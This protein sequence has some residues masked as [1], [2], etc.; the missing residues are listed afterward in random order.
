MLVVYCLACKARDRD[1]RET[2][3]TTRRTNYYKKKGGA[4]DTGKE[5]FA[6]SLYASNFDEMDAESAIANAR[7]LRH[8]EMLGAKRKKRK[9]N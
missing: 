6:S 1:G 7:T 2:R 4:M 3:V 5:V 9:T 8:I